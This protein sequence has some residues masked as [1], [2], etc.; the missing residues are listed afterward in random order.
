[1]IHPAG[2]GAQQSESLH[3]CTIAALRWF[4][5]PFIAHNPKKRPLFQN[6]I[7]CANW[8]SGGEIALMSKDAPNQ[9]AEA[10]AAGCSCGALGNCVCGHPPRVVNRLLRRR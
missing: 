3:L 9:L 2:N 7:R 8:A 5:W 6:L 4:N 10:V 1:M